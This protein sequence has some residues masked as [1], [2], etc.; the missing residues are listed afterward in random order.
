MKK[1]SSETE[2]II[3]KDASDTYFVD[4]PFYITS[5]NQEEL[6][7]STLLE[8]IDEYILAVDEKRKLFKERDKTDMQ[9]ALSK[10]ISSMKKAVNS[11]KL[12]TMT[13]NEC[14]EE[15][16]SLY[17]FSELYF[18]LDTNTDNYEGK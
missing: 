18:E 17:V 8:E 16:V 3:S 10:I 6:S 4:V 7:V 2:H 15:V 14:Y 12:G 5:K 1:I 11:F 9:N 13:F